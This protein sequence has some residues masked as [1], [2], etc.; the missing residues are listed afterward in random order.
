VWAVDNLRPHAVHDAGASE[1]I[2][3]LVDYRP[4]GDLIS[5]VAAGSRGLG[6]RD[7]SAEQEIKAMTRERYRKN[8]WRSARYEIFKLLWRRRA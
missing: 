7:D 5:A 1:R 3:V 8:R 2:N 6:V 4:S